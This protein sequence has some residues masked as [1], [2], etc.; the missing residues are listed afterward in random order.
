MTEAAEDTD[1]LTGI[2][3]VFMPAA[4]RVVTSCCVNQVDLVENGIISSGAED[5]IKHATVPVLRELCIRGI[6]VSSH[7]CATPISH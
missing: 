4:L 3:T 5:T 2:R 6:G 7:E 1:M